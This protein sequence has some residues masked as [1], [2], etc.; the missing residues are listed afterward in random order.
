MVNLL[1]FEECES[2][3]SYKLFQRKDIHPVIIRTTKNM[4][5]FSEEYLRKTDN[6]D[7]YTIN[8]NNKIEDEIINFKKL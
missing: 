3:L 8:Y 1:Y 6:M 5:F 2:N 7:I 4:N